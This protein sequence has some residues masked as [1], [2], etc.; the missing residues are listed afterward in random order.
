MSHLIIGF[1][2]LIIAIAVLIVG[3]SSDNTY[4][5]FYGNL[6]IANVWFASVS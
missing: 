5:I 4:I 2:F 3:K 1:L 6:I